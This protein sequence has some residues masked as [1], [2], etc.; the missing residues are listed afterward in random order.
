MTRGK[1]TRVATGIYRDAYGYAIV[2]SIDGNQEERRYHLDSDLDKL[3]LLRQ[4]WKLERRGIAIQTRAQTFAPIAAA[5]LDTFKPKSRRRVDVT[6]ALN[7]WLEAGFKTLAI[8]D[9][10]PE[11]IAT[12]LAAWSARG[13]A[14]STLRHRRRE[15]GNLFTWKYGAGGINPVRAVA[16][17]PKTHRERP[18]DFPYVVARL[19]LFQMRP[20]LTKTRLR[21]MLETGWPHEVLRRLKPADLHLAQRTAYIAPRKKGKGVQGR[22]VPLHRRAV[23]ALRSLNHANGY[24]PFSASSMRQSFLVAVTKAKA[25]WDAHEWAEPTPWPAPEDIHPYDL[26][27]A[28]IARAV[29][30]SGIEAASYLAIHADIRQTQEYDV[31]QALFD[32]AKDAVRD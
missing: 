13:V 32:R 7:H 30:K 28:F 12:Q 5:F 10:T 4:Q 2:T 29:R 21:V 26:R 3:I 16:R 25:I 20:S 6:I 11:R 1:R 9:I 15:L 22:T 14:N 8:E 24:G 18:R 27:H 19:I 17:A 31:E 23:A